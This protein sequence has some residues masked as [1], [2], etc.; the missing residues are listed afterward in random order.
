M[1]FLQRMLVLSSVCVLPACG[2][3][4]SPTTPAR[5]YVHFG[6]EVIAVEYPPNAPVVHSQLVAPPDALHPYEFVKTPPYETGPIKQ[7]AIWSL[8]GYTSHD[9]Q[10]KV[11]PPQREEIARNSNSSRLP[12]QNGDR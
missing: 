2:Q 11:F 1:S 7:S 6:G 9:N 8:V 12:I 10:V 3:G 4:L 5:V